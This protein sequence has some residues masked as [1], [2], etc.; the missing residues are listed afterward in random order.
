MSENHTVADNTISGGGAQPASQR[1]FF[2]LLAVVLVCIVLPW[3]SIQDHPLYPPDEGRYAAG[4]RSMV[5]S[6]NV[7]YPTLYGR[8]HLTKPP[9]VYWLQGIGIRV[10]GPTELAVRWPGVLAASLIMVLTLWFGRLV[11]GWAG[12]EGGSGP[13]P[14]AGVIS[15]AILA[16]MPVFMLVAR[17]AITDAVLGLFWFGALVFGYRALDVSASRLG[18]RVC[19]AC[20]MWVCIALGL[21]TK[22]PL[23]V[24]PLVVLIVWGILSGRTWQVLKWL[25]PWFGLPLALVPVG[26]W[27]YE[28]L[29][30]YPEAREIWLHE[31]V[32][33]ATGEGEHVA[34]FLFY[35]PVFLAG[36]F[37]A[38]AIMTWPWLNYGWRDMWHSLRAGTVH[39][40]LMVSVLLPLIVLSFISGKLPTYIFPLAPSAALLSAGLMIKWVRG[41]GEEELSADASDRRYRVP[42]LMPGLAVI[43]LCIALGAI[44]YGVFAQFVKAEPIAYAVPPTMLAVPLLVLPIAAFWAAGRLEAAGLGAGDGARCCWSSGSLVSPVCCGGTSLRIRCGSKRTVPSW[45]RASSR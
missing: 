8:P 1:R 25:Q 39:S 33:R 12:R 30:H 24:S 43:S 3:V 35:I 21:L 44:G 34:P 31:T 32:D 9:L 26:W 11:H 10:L 29:A 28:V 2:V 40:L 20:L 5:E 45:Q 7:L 13:D 27:V 14:P 19:S 41:T 6:G 4:S 22:G 36:V 15:I 37:P 38:T 42:T 16:V 17:L 18:P 23:A